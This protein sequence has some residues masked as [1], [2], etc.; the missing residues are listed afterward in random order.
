MTL[1]GVIFRHGGEA[2]EVR[3]NF[4]ELSTS[5]QRFRAGGPFS[6]LRDGRGRNL[7]GD[8]LDEAHGGSALDAAA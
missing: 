7:H 1:T 2:A 6:P 8:D 3:G 5:R 4:D